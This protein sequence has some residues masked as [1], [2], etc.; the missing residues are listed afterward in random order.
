MCLCEDGEELPLF[1]LPL[2][3]AK[4]ALQKWSYEANI[5]ISGKQW[6]C[7][8][9]LQLLDELISHR[10]NIRTDLILQSN[11]CRSWVKTMYTL[12]KYSQSKLCSN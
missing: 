4:H 12:L 11:F 6:H 3:F 9:L 7:T 1:A 2:S 10:L 5:S 8:R